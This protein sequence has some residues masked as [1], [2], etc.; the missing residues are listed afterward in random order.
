MGL[1]QFTFFKYV[2]EIYAK[3]GNSDQKNHK[4]IEK[5]R[6]VTYSRNKNIIIG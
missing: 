3:L 2:G 5:D 1:V 4:W 6:P